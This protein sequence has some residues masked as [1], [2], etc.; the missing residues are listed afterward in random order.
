MRR[1]QNMKKIIT[2]FSSAFFILFWTTLLFAADNV[3]VESKD[4]M[5]RD[6]KAIKEEIPNNLKE[7]K[8][9]FIKKSNEVQTSAEQE[10]KEIGQG[11][12]NIKPSASE[13]K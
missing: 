1:E 3:M 2:Y 8:E 11:F 12:K 4:A 7:T 5:V 13:K 6:I 10:V 9:E